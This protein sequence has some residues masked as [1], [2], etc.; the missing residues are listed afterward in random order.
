MVNIKEYRKE[1]YLKNRDKL[2]DYQNEYYIN[3]R[4][5]MSDYYFEYNK[6]TRENNKL[7]KKKRKKYK[8][9]YISNKL[10]EEQITQL[11]KDRF[12][13][14]QIILLER[15]KIKEHP[16]KNEMINKLNLLL[17]NKEI[18]RKIFLSYNK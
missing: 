6:K 15:K 5:R 14:N 8:T 10:Y 17:R 16:N 13:E 1:Y 18:V 4:H 12:I 9:Q 3:N 7:L 11:N 2:L